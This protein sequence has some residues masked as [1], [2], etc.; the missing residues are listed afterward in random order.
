MKKFLL[1]YV[2]GVLESVALL[3]NHS[4]DGIHFRHATGVCRD[5]RRLGTA[6]S[7]CRIQ[8]MWFRDP[9]G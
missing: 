9:H 3:G 4:L 2:R 8:R 7:G 1:F 5:E 6:I